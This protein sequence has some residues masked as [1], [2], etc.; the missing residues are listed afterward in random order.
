MRKHIAHTVADELNALHGMSHTVDDRE[1]FMITP[2]E[3]ADHE[4]NEPAPSAPEPTEED[5]D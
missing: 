5:G 4:Q 3:L 1:M 2:N